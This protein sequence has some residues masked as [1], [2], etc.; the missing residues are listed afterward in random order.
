MKHL[1][2]VPAIP[3]LVEKYHSRRIAD[4]CLVAEGR[5]L[6]SDTFEN[7]DDM[8]SC[9]SRGN[10]VGREYKKNAGEAASAAMLRPNK[11]HAASHHFEGNAAERSAEGCSDGSCSRFLGQML[12]LLLLRTELRRVPELA[13]EQMEHF[14]PYCAKKFW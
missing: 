11:V 9:S 13:N 6:L 12:E 3:C 7:S 5:G 1:H 8:K 14:V 2:F 4:D 10:N